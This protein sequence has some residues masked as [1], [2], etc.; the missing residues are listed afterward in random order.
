MANTLLKPHPGVTHTG[1]IKIDP[2]N[3]DKFLEAF[4]I[5]WQEVCKE[6][7]CV[8][9]EVFYSKTDSGVFHFVEVWAKDND[10]F[11]DVQ[12]KKDYY[13]AYWEVTKPMWIEREL[14]MYDRLVGLS[15]IDKRYLQGVV[16]ATADPK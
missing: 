12:I 4:R 10:W 5:C 16:T 11:M 7:E 8:Y 13:K 3:I 15:F 1:T 6:P 9:F 2:R 14:K